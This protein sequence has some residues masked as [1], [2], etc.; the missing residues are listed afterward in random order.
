MGCEV[1]DDDRTKSTTSTSS[2]TR[3]V[4]LDRRD[5]A[6]HPTGSS[7][8]Q[9]RAGECTAEDSI[10]YPL[11]PKDVT[12]IVNYLHSKK[13]QD[14]QGVEKDYMSKT[15]QVQSTRA[16]FTAFF[17]VADLPSDI[18]SEMD[19]MKSVGIPISLL[20]RAR[21]WWPTDGC[22]GDVMPPA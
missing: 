22:V 21:A 1:E 20:V 15:K 2:C 8:I 7:T 3:T 9:R 16:G 14:D 10:I 19:R 11:D 6:A 18:L 17:F 5:T 4:H 12:S 13:Y